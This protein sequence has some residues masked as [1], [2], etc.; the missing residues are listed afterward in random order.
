M[1]RVKGI[2]PSPSAW[3]AEALPLS[4]TRIWWREQD[5]NLRR[6]SSTDLQSVAFDRSA[7]SPHYCMHY[8]FLRIN[9]R[10]CQ[11]KLL[12]ITNKGY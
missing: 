10:S 3:K 11:V 9:Y 5:S 2:E 12:N 1:E 7:I 8:C 4:Y 6:R